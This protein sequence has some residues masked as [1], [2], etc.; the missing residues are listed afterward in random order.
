MWKVVVEEGGGACMRP[1]KGY[2]SVSGCTVC[3]GIR[4]EGGD[5]LSSGF[6]L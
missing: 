1:E 6:S 5:K 4:V 2:A 3:L